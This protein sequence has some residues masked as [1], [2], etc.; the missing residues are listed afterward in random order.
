[1]TGR[2]VGLVPDVK[3]RLTRSVRPAGMSKHQVR[4]YEEKDSVAIAEN[5]VRMGLLPTPAARS[6]SW[7]AFVTQVADL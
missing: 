5:I 3:E 1:M 4:E 7:D 6:A 2:Q